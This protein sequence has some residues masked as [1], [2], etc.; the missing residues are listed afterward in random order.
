MSLPPTLITPHLYLPT[1]ITPEPTPQN[2]NDNANPPPTTLSILRHHSR[3]NQH[4]KLRLHHLLRIQD[5]RLLYR[6]TSRKHAI[7][8]ISFPK[9]RSRNTIPSSYLQTQTSAPSQTC[10]AQNSPWGCFGNYDI[11]ISIYTRTA[12]QQTIKKEIHDILSSVTP[13]RQ[14]INM[15]LGYERTGNGLV[16]DLLAEIH[17]EGKRGN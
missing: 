11:N 17:G 14:E 13:F 10:L 12:A 9:T 2:S 16:H 4:P 5:P 3:R 8:S 15:A 1:L 7:P 6:H